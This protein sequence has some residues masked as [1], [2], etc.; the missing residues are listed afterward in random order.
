MKNIIVYGS[1]TERAFNKLQEL[2]DNMNLKD[3][4]KVTKTSLNTGMFT[5]ELNNGDY[6]KAIRAG[7]NVRG[8]RWQYA[9]VDKDINQ[10]LFDCVVVCKFIP[11]NLNKEWNPNIKTKDY[12]EW[13]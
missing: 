6:Y 9:Y 12:Y 2:L 11:E 4:R 13:Y 10:E 1:T 7:D 3:I 8:C 5:I